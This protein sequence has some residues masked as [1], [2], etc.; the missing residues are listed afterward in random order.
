M[1]NLM[2]QFSVTLNKKHYSAAMQVRE[3]AKA[4]GLDDLQMRV[5]AGDIYK[6]SFTFPQIAHNDY[7]VEQFETLGIAEQNLNNDPTNDQA[8]EAF[9]KTA[10]DVALNLKERYKEQWVDPKDD[11][12]AAKKED[13]N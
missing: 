9:V 6:K 10:D 4:A 8:Y 5:H 7:A 12:G 3:E 2:D 13:D 11:R 1:N